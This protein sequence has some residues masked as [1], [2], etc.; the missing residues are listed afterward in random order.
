MAGVLWID[1]SAAV[2]MLLALLSPIFLCVAALRAAALWHFR[3]VRAEPAADPNT[4]ED[5]DLPVY[6]ILVPLF[7]EADGVPGL[8]DALDRLDWPRDRLEFLFITEA[9]DEPTRCALEAAIRRTGMR[10]VVVPPGAPQTKP[11]ALM[12]AL[13]QARGELVA[14]YDAEDE[15]EPDQ[16]RLA[17]AR[18]SLPGSRVGCV[19]ARL[20]IYNVM[21]SAL[22][23]QFTIEYTALFDAILPAL[24]RFGM[25]VPL[26][27]TS[28]HFR[29]L[30]LEEVGGWD[31]YNVTEDAD[32]GVRLARAGWQVEVLNSTTWE[33][34]PAGLSVWLGQ[35]TRW[36][37]GWMQTCLV[38]LRSP[39]MLRRELGL[40]AF[41]GFSILMGGVILSALIHPLVYAIAAWTLWNGTG[42]IGV[43][44]SGWG[45]VMWWL[46]AANLILAYVLGVALAVATT[47]RRHDARLAWHALFIPFYWMLVSLAAYRALVG[48]V[49]S[50][51]HWQKTAHSGRRPL[52]RRSAAE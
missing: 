31:P 50:P 29:R 27:G 23:R 2:T 24:Q 35:R 30:V 20:N 41:F 15:P 4:T 32:L 9:G 38:H 46:G 7:R 12:Y 52:D 10:V 1:A 21:Q 5:A 25:P 44:E 19:Q 48:L 22:S 28:N 47:L 11:R 14:V 13:A 40:R 17:H 3:E 34:A 39:A 6:S 16:L 8:V 49:W 18:L 45:V 51:H 36:L 43:P 33:E 26:G 37:K 42:L